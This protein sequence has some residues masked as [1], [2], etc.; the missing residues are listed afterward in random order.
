M[1]N[2]S[3]SRNKERNP[4]HPRKA[5]GDLFACLPTAMG[6]DERQSAYG[7][8]GGSARTPL[9]PRPP[10]DETREQRRW[11]RE[12]TARRGVEWR[13]GGS[14]PAPAERGRDRHWQGAASCPAVLVLEFLE[15]CAVRVRARRGAVGA[16]IARSHLP[17]VGRLA[18][19]CPRRTSPHLLASPA[20]VHAATS[21]HRRHLYF[22]STTAGRCK[23]QVKRTPRRFPTPKQPNPTIDTARPG[24][25]GSGCGSC[26]PGKGTMDTQGD[27]IRWENSWG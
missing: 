16:S 6:E 5:S 14:R 4:I 26:V 3:S 19:A 22:P 21:T 8:A 2:K 13:R 10:L 18:R 7:R 25:V 20:N 1:G 23:P 17:T 9:P 24:S 27:R 12:I 15:A 11:S